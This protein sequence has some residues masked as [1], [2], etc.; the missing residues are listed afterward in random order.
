MR[1]MTASIGIAALL[2]ASL[3]GCAAVPGFGGCNPVFEAGDSSRIVTANGSSADFPTPLVV[4]SPE[5]STLSSGDGALVRKGDQV[6]FTATTYFGADGQKLSGDTA[7][8]QRFEAGV[9]DNAIS[10]A[11]VCAHVGDRLA[12]VSTTADAYGEGAGA[13][14]N[15][16]DDDT[17]VTIIDI[18][19]AYL[20]K[21]D[22][23]N[24]L[25]QD[26]MPTVV[27]AVDGTPGVSVLAVDAPENTRFSLIKGGDGRTVKKDD[28][29][30]LHYSLWT[31]PGTKGGEP[32]PVSNTWDSHK[33]QDFTM[34]AAENGLPQGI[35]DAL[36]GQKVGSQVLLVLTPG[37]DSFTED[38]APSGADAT[39][40]FVFDILGITK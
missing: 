10:E 38:T 23:F 4:T 17:L 9:T 39:Y 30:V 21:A 28:V 11:L 6:S 3:A 34:T 27:T 36:I 8:A 7:A 26:G 35:L 37:D 14:G 33:S 5:V 1:R 31:W 32:V 16:A 15:L 2:A 20:G 25:P 19:A 40:I 24:Q 18:D 22:G 13:S 12:L 29:V